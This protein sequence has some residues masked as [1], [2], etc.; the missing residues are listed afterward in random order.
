MQVL[1]PFRSPRPSPSYHVPPLLRLSRV[2]ALSENFSSQLAAFRPLPLSSP[3]PLLRLLLAVFTL[4]CQLTFLLFL[5]W[6]PSLLG[7]ILPKVLARVLRLATRLC[8]PRYRLLLS[9]SFG[10]CLAI[11]TVFFAPPFVLS[12]RFTLPLSASFAS[13]PSFFP[14]HL[15]LPFVR[16]RFRTA[17]LQ[18]V[19]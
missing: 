5:L 4:G 1:F 9:T 7:L 16:I 11:C 3:L 15:L 2:S 10:L 8:N 18:R 19:S 6:I 13:S 12:L 17:D 14:L